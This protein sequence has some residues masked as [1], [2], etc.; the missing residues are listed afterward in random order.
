MPK[1]DFKHRMGLDVVHWRD[2]SNKMKNDTPGYV[3]KYTAYL[4]ATVKDLHEHIQRFEEYSQA[5][6]VIIA[7]LND[8]INGQ[9]LRLN[10]FLE[11][12][13]PK[14]IQLVIRDP[15]SL[16]VIENCVVLLN[17]TGH[18]CGHLFSLHNIASCATNRCPVCRST[19]QQVIRLRCVDEMIQALQK[20]TSSKDEPS[21]TTLAN[22][23]ATVKAVI[24]K[25]L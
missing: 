20:S 19:F 5:Q 22:I 3:L 4:A 9:R 21:A 16:D 15:I 10:E 25:I 23:I 12:E 13:V 2:I 17:R 14:D 1:E 7:T 18:S 6:Q 8:E 11:E 24:G